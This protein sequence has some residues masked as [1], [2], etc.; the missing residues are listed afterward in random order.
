MARVPYRRPPGHAQNREIG[1]N[2]KSDSELIQQWLASHPEHKV[3]PMRKRRQRAFYSVASPALSRKHTTDV[4]IAS[5][6]PIK[7]E[8]MKSVAEVVDSQQAVIKEL[9]TTPLKANVGLVQNEAQLKARVD[10]LLKA[11][12][13]LQRQLS[14]S[15]KASDLFL[16]D[17]LT[18]RWKGQFVKVTLTTGAEVNGVVSKVEGSYIKFQDGPIVMR[19]G[20]VKLDK[21]ERGV[22]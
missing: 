15:G 1:G 21:A 5:Q 13:A 17:Y 12:A 7:E 14:G 11:N 9:R 22:K 2:I 10:E 3:K 18:V 6:T 8:A 20:I 19:D 16:T 4:I